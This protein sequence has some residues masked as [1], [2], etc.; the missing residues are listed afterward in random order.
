MK[1]R[2]FNYL[3]TVTTL[4]S[5]SLAGEAFAESATPTNRFGLG[6][7]LHAS[8]A[9]YQDNDTGNGALFAIYHGDRIRVDDGELSFNFLPG[10]NIKL[11]ALFERQHFGYESDDAEVFSGMEDRHP[12]WGVGARFTA[13]T[14][15][16]RLRTSVFHN[17]I[18]DKDVKDADSGSS[19]DLEY[20]YPLKVGS[21]QVTPIIGM[22]WMSEEVT[23]FLYGVSATE[24][25][26]T[27]TQYQ[28]ED[29]TVGYAGIEA[30]GMMSQN[31]RL[32]GGLRL[33]SLPREIED[34]PLVSEDTA[35]R[36][37]IGIAWLF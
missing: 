34:S 15:I 35:T 13:S 25:T 33:E 32:S 12:V 20:G 22:R 16:G 19:A 8:G 9:E 17:P 3:A 30:E 14:D 4:L 36:A 24:T 37:Y 6:L 21:Y 5:L 10:R 27:R 7:S 23:D 1:T 28:G 31:I 26:L 2:N 18:D 11:E 29:A